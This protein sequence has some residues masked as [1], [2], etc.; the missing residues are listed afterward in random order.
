MGCKM[1][2]ARRAKALLWWHGGVAEPHNGLVGIPVHLLQRMRPEG[3]TLKAKHTKQTDSATSNL[4]ASATSYAVWR[5]C[6][7]KP[8]PEKTAS[9][10][11]GPSQPVRIGSNLFDL[12]RVSL[13]SLAATGPSLLSHRFLIEARALLSK[14]SVQS[15]GSGASNASS[16]HQSKWSKCHGSLP[17]GQSIEGHGLPRD[18]CPD[19]EHTLERRHAH[20][21]AHAETH[22]ETHARTAPRSKRNELRP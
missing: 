22:A 19:I 16:F 6:S 3:S 2:Q 4:K 1:L 9:K 21:D 7:R 5:H 12:H 13:A 11:H 18:R 14:C 10:L 17:H 8:D 15:D 20:A